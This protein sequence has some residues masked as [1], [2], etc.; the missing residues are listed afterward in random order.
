M[1]HFVLFMFDS[2]IQIA[3]VIGVVVL[4]FG[5]GKLPQLAK[6][7]GQSKKAFKEGLREAEEDDEPVNVDRISAGAAAPQITEMSD[8]TL[9]AELKRRAEARAEH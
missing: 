2:P 4:L 6:S 1:Y 7:I 5:A 9:A 8:D 3:M